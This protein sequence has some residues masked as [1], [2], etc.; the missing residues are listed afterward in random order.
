MGGVSGPPTRGWNT[1]AGS[2]CIAGKSSEEIGGALRDAMGAASS[3]RSS[4]ETYKS[5]LASSH[6]AGNDAGSSVAIKPFSPSSRLSPFLM[7]RVTDTRRLVGEGTYTVVRELEVKGRKCA[8]KTLRD[9]VHTSSTS[10]E[11]DGI[12]FRF[13]NAC[14]TLHTLKHP[15]VV[16]FLGVHVDSG[17]LAGYLVTELM[18]S[19]LDSY[20]QQHETPPAAVY[21]NI[22]SD[23]ALGLHYLHHLSPPIVHRNLT[24]NNVLL[25][26]TLQAKLS[27]V[28]LAE[29]LGFSPAQKMQAALDQGPRITCYLP[30]RS[31]KGEPVYTTALDCFSFGVLILHTLCGN[32]PVPS[33][34]IAPPDSDC[35]DSES[36]SEFDCRQP[37]IDAAGSTHPLMGLVQRCLN[38]DPKGRPSITVILQEI[39]KVQVSTKLYT[40]EL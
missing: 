25:S 23:V 29:I 7:S 19:S 6:A 22:L 33:V 16:R 13:V 3:S 18:N 8:G 14:K 4:S 31:L 15:N 1:Q 35:T 28:C 37:Y 40:V 2:V 20:L 39:T 34:D 24:A 36:V 32:W 30:S 5:T 12:T 21:Y 38:S 27:D 9:A 26:S 10:E 11:R 17:S